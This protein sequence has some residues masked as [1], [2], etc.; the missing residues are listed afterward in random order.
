MN[1]TNLTEKRKAKLLNNLNKIKSEISNMDSIASINEIELYIIENKYGIHFEEHSEQVYDDLKLNVPVF[2]EDRTRLIECDKNN[3]N[4]II[5]G[6]NL[7]SLYLLQKTH[8][9]SL[10]V[11]YIDPP[12]NT[13]AKDW[14]YN[15][16]YVDGNDG[17]RHSKWLSMMSNR[18]KL[19][20]NLLKRDG[21]LICA[22]DENELATVTLLLEDIFGEGYNIDTIAIVH[23]PRGVQ[24]DN[25]SYTHEY[26]LFVYR[27]GLKVIED[28]EI[29]FE[30]IDWRDL[31]DNG[32]ESLR[33]DAANCFYPILVKNDQIIGFGDD[34]TS[35][36]DFHPN[37]NVYDSETGIYSI[38]PIDVK[39]IER[40]WRYARQSVESIKHLLRVKKSKSFLDIE[41]GKNY[42]TYRTVWDDKKFD[43]NEHGTKLINYLVPNNDFDFP[44][45]L[46]TVYE[47]LYSVIKNRP[48]AIVLD[49]FAG[50][51]TTGHAV[52]KMNSDLGGNRSFILCTNNDIGFKREKEMLTKY[53]HL[54][55]SQDLKNEEIYKEYEEK[56]GIARSITFPRIKSVVS[57]YKYSKDSKILLF[58]KSLSK[59]IFIKPEDY[60]KLHKE[61]N[62]IIES[63]KANFNKI[64][65]V[66]DENKIKIWGINEGNEFISGMSANV[67][68]YKTRMLKKQNEDID[69][70]MIL[71]PHI[72]EMIQLQYCLD[73]NKSSYR[74]ILDESDLLTYLNMKS[75]PSSL[76]KIFYS[77]NIL[78]TT[79]EEVFFKSHNIDLIKIPDEYFKIE[80]QEVGESW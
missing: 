58:D 44:K 29:L 26:A 67:H 46:Y 35:L 7:H 11:I 56:Y 9:K 60:N 77:P 55:N 13:G 42:G 22:I 38:Y 50:S 40:K 5:E 41:L 79:D 33:S 19:A 66:V 75:L 65:I 32:G 64:D 63:K 28:R 74:I 51:G 78:I 43:S 10:D 36:T 76:K 4:F 80:L 8:K 53:P 48:N 62:A 23:N 24:G 68:Y 57:G 73:L 31:R 39:G 16:S 61:L 2:E 72:N 18:L 34:V 54:K 52:L 59:N 69:L 45:S 25:F 27:K 14:K 3:R 20:K 49:F 12:Y 21:V 30:D 15:N 47:C 1:S 6:D 17:Y 71:L 70:S 37:R